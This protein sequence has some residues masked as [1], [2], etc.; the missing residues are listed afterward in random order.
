ML[1]ALMLLLAALIPGC[2]A[3]GFA[4]PESV[5]MALDIPP[6]NLDPRI[7][8]DATSS[9]LIPLLF[10][11][12][13]RTDQN[14]EFQPDLAE[15]WEVPDPLTYVF[16]L[17]SDAKFH[18]GRP[19][20]GKD[21]VY[22]FRS[23]RD[24]SITTVKGA[25]YQLVESIESP[26]DRTVIFRLKE[27]FAPFLWNVASSAIGIVP[28]SS[29]PR[30]ANNPIGSGPF[31]FVRHLQDV[32][33]VIQRN[34]EYFGTKPHVKTVTFRIIP[35]AIVRALELRKGSVDA[36][37]N[38]LLPDMVEVFRRDGEL[39]VLRANGTNY[40]YLAFNMEDPVFSDLRVRQAIAYAIDRDRIIKYLWRDQ[41]RPATGVIPPDNWSYEPNVTKYSYNPEK[42]RQ[43]LRESGH[44]NLSFTFRSS[45]SDESRL[46]AAVLQQQLKDVGIN[47]EIR[48]NEFATFFADI[49]KG[50]F[51]AYS[52]RWIGANNEPD[53]FGLIFHSSRTPPNGA[54][55][56]RYSNPEVDRLIEM[57]RREADNERR[58]PIYQR[59]QQIVSEDLPYV[60]LW[61]VDNV[62][63]FNKRIH[64]MTISPAGDYDFLNQI[65]LQPYIAMR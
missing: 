40:Q 12:L 7:G 57:G 65:T 41:A 46:L 13:V 54:N 53:H 33:L 20:T 5:T 48:S 1:V 3:R 25:T 26:D 63:V 59:I 60:S 38:V 32:E 62:A 8:Q 9:R 28:E 35:E 52:A 43:L 27:P 21:V 30:F 55:R 29:G 58:K 37:L 34:D 44:S 45:N 47:M 39:S 19:V 15:R 22:T 16:H 18:D 31:K 36:A 23:M 56:G 50:N 49:Q 42:A 11:S 51:Q 14:F 61:Y 4:D 10:S 6:T 17:R 24:G 2:A 64:G